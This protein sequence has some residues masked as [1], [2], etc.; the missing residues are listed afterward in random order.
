MNTSKT[1]N[2]NLKLTIV[3]KAQSFVV[4]CY[5]NDVISRYNECFL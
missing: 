5:V 2:T 4:I 1:T 3:K